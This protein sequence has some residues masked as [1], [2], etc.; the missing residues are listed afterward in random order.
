MSNKAMRD[1]FIEELGG[2]MAVDKN[3][4]F[5]AADFGAPALDAIRRQC[6]ERFINVGI[7]EQNLIN[8]CAGLALEGFTVY[9]YAIAPFLAMRSY[10]QIRINLA[11]LSQVREINVNLISVG[12]GLS[13]DVT[14][15][16]HHCL[17]D[18][19][20]MR[21]LPNLHV[22]S[23]SDNALVTKMVDLSLAVRAPKYIRLDGKPLPSIYGGRDIP[24]LDGFCEI[25][26]AANNCII[27]TGYM[28]HT[29]VAVKKKLEALGLDAGV[30]DFFSLKHFNAEKLATVLG[31]YK[32]I[33]SIEEGFLGKGG[34]DSL[35]STFV[36]S[37]LGQKGLKVRGLGFEDKYCFEVGDRKY[38]HELSG[39][40]EDD[41]VKIIVDACG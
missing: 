25:Y 36:N 17:E 30:I 3:I 28:T 14:G 16:T 19:G 9:A 34:L 37:K 7:A 4:F 24:V 29:A 38:L 15:P 23:P 26:S 5:V 12:A 13:Y 8:V 32:N 39:L 10:E 21:M 35:V 11:M 40:A 27:A 18:I 22:L 33:F 1:V 20:I 41:V 6:G 2:R 31:K